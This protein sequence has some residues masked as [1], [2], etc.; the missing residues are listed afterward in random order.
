MAWYRCGGGGSSLGTKTI[1]ENGT[2]SAQDDGVDGYSE[3]TVNVNSNPN[4][5]EIVIIHEQIS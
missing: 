2:Y 1:T 3:V 5:K 4:A